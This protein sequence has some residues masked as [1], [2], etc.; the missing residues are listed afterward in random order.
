MSDPVTDI[1]RELDKA[2]KKIRELESADDAVQPL[3]DEVATLKSDIATAKIEIESLTLVLESQSEAL[4]DTENLAKRNDILSKEIA[5]LKQTILNNKAELDGR[6]KQ[7]SQ[8]MTDIRTLK[9]DMDTKSR[10]FPGTYPT[11]PDKRKPGESGRVRKSR[12]T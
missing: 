10:S 12:R 11:L 5:S 1:Q 7:L 8:A 3:L 2:R 9:K 4:K 6:N